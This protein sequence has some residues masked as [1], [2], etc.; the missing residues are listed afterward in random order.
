[1]RGSS[2]DETEKST[3]ALQIN[4][5]IHRI[6]DFVSRKTFLVAFICLCA[7]I[8]LHK[9]LED[10]VAKVLVKHLLSSIESTRKNDVVFGLIALLS[11]LQLHKKK[12]HV[13]SGYLAV[14]G[15]FAVFSY[16]TY[17][18][19]SDR[20]LF[21][22]FKIFPL[23]AYA[24]TFLCFPAIY[25]LLWLR[26]QYRRTAPT[27][28][29]PYLVA[30]TPL[31]ITDTDALGYEKYATTVAE[32][33]NESRFDHSFAIGVNGAWGSGKTSFINL[34]KRH[35]NIDDAIV[36][37][38]S[39]WNSATPN[40]VINDFF[41]TIQEAIAPYYSSLA[42]LL[43]IYSDKL[44]EIND[45]AI[46]KTVK[47]TVA[48]TAGGPSTR[49]IFEEINKALAQIN[50]R[51]VVFIDDLDRSD[52]NEMHEVIRL[53]RN[54]A[55]FY[56]TFFV[57]AYDRDYVLEA[58]SKRNSINY[59]KFLEKIFQIEINLPYY[60]SE[61]LK[62]I[63]QK[64]LRD[65]FP[66][67][68]DSFVVNGFA[69]KRIY[70]GSAAIHY[71]E[72]MR[73]VTRFCNYLSL[74]LRKLLYEVD[75]ID[76]MNAEILRLKYPSVYELI[77]K[78][79]HIYLTTKDSN[80]NHHKSCYK[81]AST[82]KSGEYLIRNY[83]KENLGALSLTAN[84]GERA[85]QLL[86]SMFASRHMDVYFASPLSIVFP[87]NFKKY[88]AYD[89]L[90]D[91]LSEVAFTKARASSQE[92]FNQSIEE[93]C[94]CKLSWELRARFM[95]IREYD[96]LDDFERIIAGIFHFAQLP[97]LGDDSY[98]GVRRVY[99]FDLD[100]L[101][102][103]ITNYNGKITKQFYNNDL[104]AYHSFVLGLFSKAQYPY[105]FETDLL[106]NINN[107][108][109]E[110]FPLE[111]GEVHKLLLAYFEEHCCRSEAMN[112][113]VWE[114]YHHCK[115]KEWKSENG[116]VYQTGKILISEASDVFRKFVDERGFA[117]FAYDVIEQ[118]SKT[119]YVVSNVVLELY[120]SWS[121]FEETIIKNKN[122]NEFT[123]VF[124]SFYS[125]FA[126]NDFKPVMYDF[127]GMVKK[128]ARFS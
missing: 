86:E 35:I 28:G 65:L 126:Q 27:L 84:D 85:M 68:Y 95:D 93:W 7:V 119:T 127:K 22:S 26:S 20:W 15:A 122:I 30:D 82:Q 98:G 56:N 121:S 8:L 10:V 101:R 118:V 114:F 79:T 92:V 78:S 94:Q 60:R 69:N 37:D 40:A 17:R 63:L 124:A 72:N 71:L 36:V 80:A 38:F 113:M 88:S 21:T 110:E 116:I 23:V 66:D 77:F 104:H 109:S 32:Y 57:V 48:L 100:D 111:R 62:I 67:D 29:S 64:K 83:I 75:M 50:Q 96:N 70:S 99:S 117:G 54:N 41:D 2:P 14:I 43:R 47:S 5:L 102:Q 105:Y 58:L 112:D 13:A 49:T 123:S 106:E 74:N 42:Q 61:K 4:M 3:S 1:M 89:L 44:V 108:Y 18:I 90:D 115:Y 128:S 97:T 125:E 19:A 25:L 46:T 59:N 39:S 45:N 73:E 107:N 55:N 12:K 76:F 33:I 52:A 87:S 24:D 31:S 53:I 11:L 91:N 34:V 6:L 16:V 9:P 51:L 103:K 81:L 120:G